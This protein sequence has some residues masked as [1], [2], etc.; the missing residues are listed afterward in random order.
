M[1]HR[2]RHITHLFICCIAI[3]LIACQ[4]DTGCRLETKVTSGVVVEWVS[5]DTLDRGTVINQW[6]S[7]SVLGVGNDTIL[8]ANTRNIKTLRLPLRMDT[9]Q[10]DY[11]ILWHNEIDILHILHTNDRHYLSMACGCAI[12]HTIDSV[13]SE[14]IFIDSLDI[15]NTAV[16][17]Y[18]QDNIYLHLK[19]QYAK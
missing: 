4:P 19:P 2:V 10:T 18:E 17:N 3:T 6:D 12:Y 8:Y 13:W 7:V 5:V 15:H 1:M 14:G 16:E 11:Y 9:C